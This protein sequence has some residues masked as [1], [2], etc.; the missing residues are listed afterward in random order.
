MSIRSDAGSS[1]SSE[2]RRSRCRGI[3]RHLGRVPRRADRPSI[4]TGCRPRGSS[5]PRLR[6]PLGPRARPV[7]RSATI[8][9]AA[10]RRAARVCSSC[11]RGRPMLDLYIVT[12]YV[13]RNVTGDERRR[14]CSSSSSTPSRTLLTAF[15]RGE[16]L[17]RGE[18][19][20]QGT[21]VLQFYPSQDGTLVTCLWESGLR[22]GRAVLRRP[23]A[24]RHE[25]Q[26][27]LRRRGYRRV[28]RGAAGIAERRCR[29][30]LSRST[31]TKGRHA[32]ALS[33][34]YP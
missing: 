31:K 9:S 8:R 17:Q 34:F 32:P 26:P 18:G 2:L 30:C 20:P 27:L 10:A 19:A 3:R 22:R 25:H 24:R 4:R 16:R 7:R 23:D 29:S 13:T 6:R 1:V 28:C 12:C 14:S 15:A 21:R 33:R 11:S 5:C